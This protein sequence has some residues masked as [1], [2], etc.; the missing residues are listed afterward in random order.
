MIEL[1]DCLISTSLRSAFAQQMAGT[2]APPRP[3]ASGK[4]PEMAALRR[5]ASGIQHRAFGFI[6]AQVA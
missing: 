6:H 1:E 2:T 4:G 3:I 5:H